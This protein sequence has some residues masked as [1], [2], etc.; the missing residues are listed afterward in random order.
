MLTMEVMKENNILGDPSV[1]NVHDH[2]KNTSKYNGENRKIVPGITML[3]AILNFLSC[4]YSLTIICKQKSKRS[5][6]TFLMSIW[7]YFDIFYVIM[8]TCISISFFSP[9]FIEVNKLR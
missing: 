8:N 4:L 7:A 6:M 5:L 3:F 1:F 2:I 9:N